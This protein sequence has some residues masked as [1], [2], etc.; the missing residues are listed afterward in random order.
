V[1]F[2]ATDP[3]MLPAGRPVVQ[4][5]GLDRGARTRTNQSKLMTATASTI[6]RARTSIPGAGPVCGRIG[7]AG[8][9]PWRATLPGRKLPLLAYVA[10]LVAGIYA[11]A[12]EEGP[13][14]R[15]NEPMA[16]DI[17]SQSLAT[18]LQAYGQR[19]GVQ[20]LYESNSSN[21]R[22]S[23]A[24]EGVFAPDA[25]LG[26]LLTGTDLRVRYIR[27]DAITLAPP[28]APRVASA[29]PSSP[30]SGVDLSLGTL[31]VRG[32]RDGDETARLNEYS[33]RVQMDIQNAL[34]KNARTRDGSYRAV[35]DLWIDPARTIERTEL[36]RS[37]GDRERDAAIATTLRG[38]TIS[39]PAPANAPRP[40]RISIVVTS[41]Q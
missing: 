26:L 7:T 30:L 20:V 41:L 9:F 4:S 12:A 28:D 3:N 40:V 33:E 25:A 36:F 23:V 16:F 15:P 32:S 14:A 18:A 27:P 1:P 2:S 17:P 24:V 10:V 21:G 8:G 29:P 11:A 13:V 37:T 39:R 35:L 22:T 19:T 34:R 5:D 31:R 6:P 38:V